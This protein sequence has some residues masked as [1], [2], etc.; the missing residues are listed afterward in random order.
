MI[1]GKM[2]S[3]R[4]IMGFLAVG[5]IAPTMSAQAE[6]NS[7]RMHKDPLC[8]C[9]GAWAKHMQ[10]SGFEVKIEIAND[11]RAIRTRLGV[12]PELGSCHSAEIDGYVIEGHV[13]AE[14]VKRLLAERPN[15]KGLA[16][17]GMP[18]GSPGMGG[19]AEAY[20]VT[21]FGPDGRSA[22]MRFVGIKK[23]S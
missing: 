15:A 19:T 5:V 7:I 6:S 23:I 10:R 22:Y 4:T 1:R 9:C 3:R 11:L 16:V 17:P 2:I 12:P 18:A 21:L 13:P 8:G 14:A 20:D